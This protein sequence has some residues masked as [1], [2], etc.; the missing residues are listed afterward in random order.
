MCT[1]HSRKIGTRSLADVELHSHPAKPATDWLPLRA[2]IAGT[3]LAAL[4]R[5]LTMEE[6]CNHEDKQISIRN[7]SGD[8]HDGRR[9]G[10]AAE[11]TTDS[12]CETCG[13]DVQPVRP[14][15]KR[16]SHATTTLATREAKRSV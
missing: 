5:S 1:P 16:A 11:P 13:Y 2:E 10:A 3:R 6:R 14:P 15:H 12:A 8:G 7:I 4:G 9:D